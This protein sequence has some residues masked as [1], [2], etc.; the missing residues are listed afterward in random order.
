MSD[1]FL[2]CQA[3]NIVTVDGHHHIYYQCGEHKHARWKPPSKI[4]L[5]K[6]VQ[7]RLFGW[8]A[9]RQHVQAAL[10]TRS[11]VWPGNAALFVNA[12]VGNG[13]ADLDRA[14]VSV[15]ASGS[16]GE[17][18]AGESSHQAHLDAPLDSSI[19][20]ACKGPC[21][22]LDGRRVHLHFEW[23]GHFV[24]FGFELRPRQL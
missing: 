24:V 21:E 1:L 15:L 6:F 14:T 16:D 20:W 22:R 2:G 10:T 3:S 7:D 8:V 13:N 9:Q 12:E 18:S 17:P 11:F 23:T 4:Y 19:T 5:A